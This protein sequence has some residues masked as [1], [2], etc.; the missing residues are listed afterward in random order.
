MRGLL[1]DKEIEQLRE[2]TSRLDD[3]TKLARDVS[4]SLPE[5]IALRQGKDKQLVSALLPTVEEIL[6]SS[7]KRDPQ[8][9]SR[10]LFPVMGPAIR[11]SIAEAIRSMIQSFN[12]ALEHSFSLRGLK[13]RLLALRTGKSF[14]EI[15]LLHSL[16]Y[17]VEQVFL[18]HGDTGLLLQHAVAQ[19][20]AYQDA[21][22]VSG[23]FTAIQDFVRDSFDPNAEESLDVLRIGELTIVVERGASAYLAAVVRGEPPEELHYLF[24]DALEAIVLQ[25]GRELVEFA[26]DAE[27]FE[28]IRPQ[29]E[30][31]LV[32]RY[33]RGKEKGLSLFPGAAAGRG[34]F[35]AG[36]GCPG[37]TRSLRLEQHRG[38]FHQ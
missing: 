10:A 5:A 34:R 9:L 17:R 31:C 1:V 4:R 18:I 23:M 12:H 6:H 27:P 30:D 16:E 15:V 22:M 25:K 29:L 36:L 13:W 35:L 24:S 14:A 8:T 11:K 37:D 33:P 26:G 2:L 20:V 21:D 28:A 3:A 32:T 38:P 19:D 7:V